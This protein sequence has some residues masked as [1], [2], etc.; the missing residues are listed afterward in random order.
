MQRPPRG[1]RG[2]AT[3]RRVCPHHP[4]RLAPTWEHGRAP[5]A[6]CIPCVSCVPCVPCVCAGHNSWQVVHASQQPPPTPTQPPLTHRPGVLIMFLALRARR[7]SFPPV[8]VEKNRTEHGEE[9]RGTA[10]SRASIERHGRAWVHL[11]HLASQEP[12]STCVPP[13]P[14]PLPLPPTPPNCSPREG[15]RTASRKQNA[16]MPRRSTCRS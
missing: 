3:G 11:R 12:P 13:P 5:C 8:A 4:L 2:G 1:T 14:P 10:C 9:R 7:C 6:P 16:T 15:K